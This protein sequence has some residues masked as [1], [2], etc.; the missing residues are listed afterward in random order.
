MDY[1][2]HLTLRK[3]ERYLFWED[4]DSSYGSKDFFYCK[5]KIFPP[6]YKK[7]EKN[8]LL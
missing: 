6:N 4:L 3:E 8:T 7:K 2:D 1:D 5:F